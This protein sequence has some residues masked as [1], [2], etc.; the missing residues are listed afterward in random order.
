MRLSSFLLSCTREFHP[1]RVFYFQNI[2]INNLWGNTPI[3]TVSSFQLSSLK[4]SSEVR[5]KTEYWRFINYIRIENVI[6]TELSQ[7]MFPSE[8]ALAQSTEVHKRQT[9]TIMKKKTVLEKSTFFCW[10]GNV[11][12][13]LYNMDRSRPVICQIRIREA[14]N[15]KEG[16][17]KGSF[18]SHKQHC[19]ST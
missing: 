2:F 5:Y 7:Q 4:R 12:Q 16:G 8:I 1:K 3:F 19:H 18:S 13:L 10:S 17:K 14:L 11:S 15:N 6:D 9:I